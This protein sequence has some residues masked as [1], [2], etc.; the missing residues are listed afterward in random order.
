[1]LNHAHHRSQHGLRSLGAATQ[2]ALLPAAL[3]FV[4]LHAGETR[5]PAPQSAA[6][7]LVTPL[8]SDPG[9]VNV[10]RWISGA[11]AEPV[12]V[13]A[14]A[15]GERGAVTVAFPCVQGDYIVR[16]A[17]HV[18]WPFRL[19]ETRCA[20]PVE[21]P[22]VPSAR[23]RGRIV[24]PRDES[25]DGTADRRTSG[26][27][28][29]APV[30][31]SLAA[32]SKDPDGADTGSHGLRPEEDGRFELTVPA[33][34]IRFGLRMG[35]FAP[36]P[37]T[38]V[39]LKPG[40]ACDLGEIEMRRGATLVV[41]TRRRGNPA[42]GADVSVVRPEEYEE[43]LG[44][45][46]N[47]GLTAPE[48]SGISN[49]S[50]AAAF[51]GIDPGLVQV[52]ASFQN[53]L[54]LTEPVELLSGEIAEAAVELF[55]PA[56]AVVAIAGDLAG[57]QA[58]IRVDAVGPPASGGFVAS[59]W[60]EPEPLPPEGFSLPLVVPGRW[61]FEAWAEDVLLDRQVADVPPE[62]AVSIRLSAERRRFRGRVRV[63][64]EPLGGSLTLLHPES[65]QLIARADVQQ[66]GRFTVGLPEPGVYRVQFSNAANGIDR[67]QAQ[68]EFTAGEE[69]DVRLVPTRIDGR[70]VFGDGRPAAGAV[71]VAGRITGEPTAFG[72]DSSGVT[73]DGSG[74]FVI[75]TI[76][77]GE[78]HLSARLGVRRSEPIRVR[79]G[80]SEAE[81]LQLVLSDLDGVTVQVLN[82][83]GE[84]APLV[85]GWL[86]A[87]AGEA[88]MPFAVPFATGADGTAR[89]AAWLAPGS[90]VQ[91]LLTSSD[92][93]AGAFRAA[94]DAD[95]LVTVTAASSSGSLR[96]LLPAGA[97]GAEDTSMLALVSDRGGVLPFSLM[98]EMGLLTHTPV[99]A[100]VSVLLPALTSGPW[101]LAR[102]S[103][104]RAM[105]QFYNG[106][107][108]PAF[109]T[110]F[111]LPPGGSVTLDLR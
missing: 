72:T 49:A 62:G 95:G 83:A 110:S 94:P 40:E 48:R 45:W 28:P 42:I 32:C 8:S 11:P 77:A 1:M 4:V 104:T 90:W 59:R 69:A 82:A 74:A 51:I 13:Q 65:R 3:A 26:W 87:P 81:P 70:V 7:L 92:C 64:D 100:S 37:P 16:T 15:G 5:P 29:L 24:R 67:A 27:S 41:S 61:R 80:D 54:G 43:F 53:T 35:T 63:G 105:F 10:W 39:T 44:R 66:D 36:I 111:T 18:S 75:R 9:P 25:R 71:V 86:M 98:A 23:L 47:K 57:H 34:C 91:V 38:P 96:V 73:T 106:G 14:V 55:G 97:G 6:L 107:S 20:R 58:R 50:G 46:L 99:G 89:V 33:G 79:V 93:P 103:D 109:L 12:D 21:V 2:L 52:L 108:G 56:S 102:F 88:A 76:E 17:S 60:V 31:V 78:D 84:P 68:A 101:Q 30:G 22:L 19:D 85:Q